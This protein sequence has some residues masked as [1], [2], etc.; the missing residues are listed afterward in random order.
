[1]RA[2]LDHDLARNKEENKEEN[3]DDEMWRMAR[4]VLRACFLLQTHDLIDKSLGNFMGHPMM[5]I[6]ESSA[7]NGTGR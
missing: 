1:L 6:L 7:P 3:K 5:E 2:K 4:F